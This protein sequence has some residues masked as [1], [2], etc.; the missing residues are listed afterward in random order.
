M[1]LFRR[2]LSLMLVLLLMSGM[3]L[4]AGFTALAADIT[5]SSI[6]VNTEPA[7]AEYT[8]GEKLDLTGLTAKLH[9]SD[10]TSFIYT[11][12]QFADKNI[13]VTPENG[14]VLTTEGKQKVTLSYGDLSASFELTVNPVIFVNELTV[15]TEP[16]RTEYTVGEKLDLAGLTAKLRYSDENSNIFTPDEFADKNITVTPENGTVLTTEGKQKVTLSYGDLSASFEINVL[17]AEERQIDR[18]FGSDRYE[19]AIAISSEGWKQADSVI[20]ASGADFAD[21]LAGAGLSKALNAPILLVSGKDNAHVYA[22]IERLG[23]VNAW[24]LGGENA[25]SPVVSSKLTGMGLSVNRLSGTDRYATAA[26]IAAQLSK[27]NGEADKAFVVSGESF[28]D[29]LSAGYASAV[30]GC[31]ILYTNAGNLNDTTA[32]YITSAGINEVTI[33]GGSAAVSDSAAGQLA[34]L[35]K[36]GRIGGE[37][38]YLTSLAVSRLYFDHNASDKIAVATGKDFPDALT[39][40]AYAIKLGM[41][42]LLLSDKVDEELLKYLDDCGIA[43]I[44]VFGGESAIS[45]D[46]ADA[47]K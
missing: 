42:V 40:G 32:Q 26:A 2:M 1:K 47:L 14:T 15:N 29:A 6:S 39:G 21:A 17:P 35:A 23:A 36:V 43:H 45:S 25:V 38:R 41:P 37:D 18:I 7:R 11:F 27:L 46:V 10:E 20:I 34:Q 9:F 13:T 33:I 8:V 22:E 44:T 3:V 30:S 16:T 19:T 24:I 12:D 4:P 5:V 28:A 31:P